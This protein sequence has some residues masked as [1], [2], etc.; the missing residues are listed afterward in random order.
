MYVLRHLLLCP[1]LSPPLRDTNTC[2]TCC[3][4]AVDFSF[5]SF[6]PSARSSAVMSTPLAPAP[7][8]S[9][10]YSTG[11]AYRLSIASQPHARTITN[12][13]PSSYSSAKVFSTAIPMGMHYLQRLLPFLTASVV[14]VSLTLRCPLYGCG[15]HDA[16]MGL[17][18]G[19]QV[20]NLIDGEKGLEIMAITDY[21]FVTAPQ[22]SL[23]CLLTSFECR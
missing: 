2:R 12:K 15:R 8:T 22:G 20:L 16:E 6:S 10:L 19:A 23:S 17:H 13:V 11:I 9:T 3:A 7:T 1:L 18:Q 21:H 14:T 4:L 5:F